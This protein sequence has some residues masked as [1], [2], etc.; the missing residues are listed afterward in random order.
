[1]KEKVE[2]P[3]WLDKD[4]EAV[5]LARILKGRNP[6]T[7]EEWLDYHICWCAF[8]ND[9]YMGAY[10]HF[11]MQ[12]RYNIGVVFPPEIIC[13]KTIQSY[14]PQHFRE[15]CFEIVLLDTEQRLVLYYLVCI[16]TQD[17]VCP[18][19]WRI[20]SNTKAEYLHDIDVVILQDVLM[21]HNLCIDYRNKCGGNIYYWSGIIR[22]MSFDKGYNVYERNGS[23]VDRLTP[24]DLLPNFIRRIDNVETSFIVGDL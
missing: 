4:M 1:M 9:D 22:I 21:T 10:D 19:S 12:P 2:Q 17:G 14:F 5:Y 16:P 11:I 18:I 20:P 23:A 15:N 8:N 13:V 6:K 24:K 7:E 3:D